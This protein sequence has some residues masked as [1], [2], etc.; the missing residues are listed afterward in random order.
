MRRGDA[1]LVALLE[2]SAALM[3][4]FVLG[5]IACGSLRD[6]ESLLELLNDLP[7]VTIA[8]DDEAMHFIERHRL[9]GKGMGYVDVHLLASVA[10]TGGAKLWT[11]DQRLRQAAASLGWAHSEAAH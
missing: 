7:G 10:L 4:P 2:R 9:Q 5:E 6:R 8:T 11:R 1:G 3:H